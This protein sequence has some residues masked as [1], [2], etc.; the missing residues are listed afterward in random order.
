MA[1]YSI[2]D[3]EK[4]SGIKAHTIRIWEQR[5]NLIEPKRTPTNIRYYTDEDLKYLL[6]IAF[7]NKNGV[8]ISKISRMSAKEIED[9]VASLS[10]SS[11]DQSQQ[12]RALTLAMV[13]LNEEKFVDILDTS[14]AQDAWEPSIV[15]LII[16]FLE[17]LSLL[18]LT[19]SISLVHEQFVHCI[20]RRKLLA[21]IEYLP[22]PK[23]K[24]RFMLCMPKGEDQELGL[25]LIQ[26]LL[27]QRGFSV[28]YLGQNLGLNDLELAARL[29]KPNFLYLILSDDKLKSSLQ[30]Y[31]SELQ[32][33][34]PEVFLLISGI[35]AGHIQ[36][37]GHTQ[38]PIRLFEDISDTIDF[39]D[40]LLYDVE[41]I[42]KSTVL[43]EKKL[44]SL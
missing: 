14:I 22:P 39:L 5:Y 12:L 11:S 16:P 20:I 31:I 27:R 28:L 34:M 38:S 18:W 1:T 37:S 25:L 17:K 21:A 6:N 23:H 7:L 2:R 43:A 26:Y 30:D 29:Q 35:Q 32:K 3:L 40:E 36:F 10:Q 24:L 13:E 44:K 42:E 4:L 9:K 15:Q 19:G 8:R 33:R 41:E